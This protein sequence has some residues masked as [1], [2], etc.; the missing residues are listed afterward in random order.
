MSFNILLVI[1]Y[2][3][4]IFWS[5]TTIGYYVE[6]KFNMFKKLNFVTIGFIVNFTIL[7]LFW[8]TCSII[9]MLLSTVK[10]ITYDTVF[11][12]MAFHVPLSM[13]IVDGAL[14]I[15]I[16]I[17][18]FKD[19]G[20]IFIRV[21]NF[22]KNNKIYTFATFV[23]VWFSQ[24]RKQL[25]SQGFTDDWL[26]LNASSRNY[27]LW[28]VDPHKIFR[29]YSAA[30]HHKTSIVAI[31]QHFISMFM[32]NIQEMFYFLLGVNTRYL[33][34]F[35]NY[36]S[37]N[38]VLTIV[39]LITIITLMKRLKIPS[40]FLLISLV[41]LYIESFNYFQRIY[42]Q[43][44]YGM[45]QVAVIITPILIT[46]ILVNKEL[47]WIEIGIVSFL[48][49]LLHP[50][51]LF[52]L[53]P[54]FI[55]KFISKLDHKKLNWIYTIFIILAIG[56]ALY[57]GV[58]K[59][60][61]EKTFSIHDELKGFY[62]YLN[63]KHYMPKWWLFSPLLYF[64]PF[65][66]KNRTAKVASM[67]LAFAALVSISYG[68]AHYFYIVVKGLNFLFLRLFEILF[69]YCLI[70]VTPIWFSEV[71]EEK[72]K[73]KRYIGFAGV[74]IMVVLIIRPHRHFTFDVEKTVI[75][76]IAEIRDDNSLNSMTNIV[77]EVHKISKNETV[78]IFL[79]FQYR[80]NLFYLPYVFDD[81]YKIN[82]N[83]SFGTDTKMFFLDNLSNLYY[84]LN[85]VI[86]NYE[87]FGRAEYVAFSP[88]YGEF[89][90][91]PKY[92]KFTN[93]IKKYYVLQKTMDLNM[94]YKGDPVHY[95][96]YKK[97]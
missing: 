2:A 26:Y 56:V 97:K 33:Q 85:K 58:I 42:P 23:F 35:F 90:S 44:F 39:S 36:C 3:V 61:N 12:F 47:K 40:Y 87:K 69:F 38:V 78:N 66:I 71:K 11:K 8:T 64:V 57:G 86:P 1:L 52:I 67:F 63:L 16:Q 15:F 94:T 46:Y 31:I 89:P 21:Y 74:A 22:I 45:G 41:F 75:P 88:M 5:F 7:A 77:D 19:Y 68:W 43:I 62:A 6:K 53:V 14:F 59:H 29:V 73:Y 48:G 92:A 10:I 93:Y 81:T 25:F 96:I 20:K 24:T 27:F 79:P 72:V 50:F 17:M 28:N 91:G 49:L 55:I 76:I 4:V 9:L 18:V 95:F 80:N 82:R 37:L 30:S 34:L 13:A 51:T 70:L 54:L 32:S 83:I 60:Y 65:M 84:F